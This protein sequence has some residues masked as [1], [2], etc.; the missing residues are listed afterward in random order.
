MEK[1]MERLFDHI[2]I[3][4]DFDRA[5]FIDKGFSNARKYKL[6]RSGQAVYLLRVY[7]GATYPRR[8]EEHRHIQQHYDN[9]VVC[10]K[11]IHHG[12]V[13]ELALCYIVLAYIEGE[14]GESV[15]PLLTTQEQVEQGYKAGQ[16]LRKIH[17][18]AAPSDLNWAEKRYAKYEQKKRKVL[19][20]G[21][22]FHKQ[23]EMES[24]FDAH[25]ELLKHS[26]VC[27]QHDDFLESACD[28]DRWSSEP[29]AKRDHD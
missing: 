10:Q 3:H 26:T 16:E 12:Y 28:L 2:R 13:P 22:R 1:Q 9:G 19:E 8:K 21:L 5:E 27:F 6:Y 25:I 24:F 23:N 14:S 20:L 4:Y 11:P 29:A 7:D 18:I 15:L 17:R